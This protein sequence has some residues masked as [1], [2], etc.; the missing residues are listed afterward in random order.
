[1][2]CPVLPI[3]LRQVLHASGS[4]VG[5]VDSFD[6]TTQNIVQG[7]SGAVSD[8]LQ[9]QKPI[10]LARVFAG[11]EAVEQARGEQGFP[12]CREPHHRF[13]ERQGEVGQ[14]E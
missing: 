5:L 11:A 12:H 9:R 13:G 8:H 7:F 6:Q 1:M 3:F 10:A 2:L 14:G 4:I